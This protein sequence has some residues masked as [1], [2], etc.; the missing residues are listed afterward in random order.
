MARAFSQAWELLK[1][2]SNPHDEETNYYEYK[3]QPP[4]DDMYN[5]DDPMHP[6]NRQ[7]MTEPIM[8]RENASFEEQEPHW[9][10]E[11]MNHQR[12][13]PKEIE[14]MM[15]AQEEAQ[16]GYP[17]EYVQG[18]ESPLR[19]YEPPKRKPMEHAPDAGSPQTIPMSPRGSV[20]GRGERQ[21]YDKPHKPDWWRHLS[22]E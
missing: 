3:R 11:N 8:E 18:D 7:P 16:R 5:H 20:R 21:A 19:D 10:P 15:E 2:F 6:K 9:L 13:R 1:Q 4:N 17:S 22:G 14:A 12:V